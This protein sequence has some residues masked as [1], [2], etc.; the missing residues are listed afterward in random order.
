VVHREGGS[1]HGGADDHL[2]EVAATI[3]QL[4]ES[5]IRTA[6]V[7]TKFRYRIERILERERLEH[8]FEVIVGGEDVFQHKPD[9]EGLQQALGRLKIVPAHAVYVGDH[10]VDAEAASRAA[11]DFIAVLTGMSR[12]HEFA[13]Y[14]VKHVLST[15]TEL[16]ATLRGRAAP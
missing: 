16:P 1:G 14:R 5:G 3:A 6:I 7:S 9:P 13:E 12:A 10:P 8:A 15:L 11:V 4:L 2:P